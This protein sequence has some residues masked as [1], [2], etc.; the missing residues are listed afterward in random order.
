[1]MSSG[2]SD[3]LGEIDSVRVLARVTPDNEE[4][5]LLSWTGVVSSHSCDASDCT[6][7]VAFYSV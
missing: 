2:P 5:G 1:M 6:S 3:V 7:E 4:A